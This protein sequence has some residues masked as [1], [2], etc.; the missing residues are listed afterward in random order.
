MATSLV[1]LR[2]KLNRELGIV[3][4]A[5]ALPWSVAARNAAI[6]DAYA[7]LWLKGARKPV[8]QTI[9]TVD[10]TWR[11]ALTS[12]QTVD[13]VEL[14]DSSSNVME[15][16][17]ATADDDGSGGFALALFSPIIG[18]Y[19]MRVWGWQPYVSTFAS[20][21]AVDDLPAQF[22]R[23]PILKAKSILLRQELT[24]FARWRE[25]ESVPPEMNVTADQFIGIIA[26]AEREYEAGVKMLAAQRPRVMRPT[27]VVHG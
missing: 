1:N 26:A 14:L 6:E 17:R 21:A 7:D 24:S 16:V 12:I 10:D 25:R 23:L 5:E 13:R 15:I 3:S 11:Y 20:D 2:T 18:G 8:T 4:D 22:N 19:S 9:S 27:R